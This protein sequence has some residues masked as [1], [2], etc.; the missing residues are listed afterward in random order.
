MD[1][2]VSEI[3]RHNDHPPPYQNTRSQA[4]FRRA[5]CAPAVPMNNMWGHSEVTTPT[6]AWAVALQP[7]FQAVVISDEKF[8]YGSR[9]W[10]LHLVLCPDCGSPGCLKTHRSWFKATVFDELDFE[11]VE[12]YLAGIACQCLVRG[13]QPGHTVGHTLR[14]VNKKPW[15]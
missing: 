7:E 1:Y 5:D 15:P 14:R 10:L 13:A 8:E 4:A 11:E 9:T 2:I 12:D 3:H 6:T